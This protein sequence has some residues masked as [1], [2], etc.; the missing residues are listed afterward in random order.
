LTE[1]TLSQRLVPSEFLPFGGLWDYLSQG[2]CLKCCVMSVERSRWVCATDELDRASIGI[3]LQ[4]SRTLILGKLS[5]Y[6]CLCSIWPSSCLFRSPFH[7]PWG[8]A[9]KIVKRRR[10]KSKTGIYEAGGCWRGRAVRGQGGGGA[11]GVRGA[12]EL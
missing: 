5:Y 3:P 7:D 2:M 6:I 10:R 12:I 9:C 4:G 8:A 11:R 1:E